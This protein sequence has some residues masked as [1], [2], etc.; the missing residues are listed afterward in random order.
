LRKRD[1]KKERDETER[2]TRS[3]IKREREIRRKREIRES[4]TRALR[5]RESLKRENSF[6]ASVRRVAAL[7]KE[8]SRALNSVSIAP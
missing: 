4:L 3:L 7:V 2:E 1:Q 8:L 5:E 6:C